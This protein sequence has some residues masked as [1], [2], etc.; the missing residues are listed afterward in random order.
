MVVY[1]QFCVCVQDVL[2]RVTVGE[3]LPN[4]FL[5]KLFSIYVC[6]HDMEVEG[7]CGNIGFLICGYDRDNFNTV[8]LAISCI[9]IVT[10]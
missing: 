9:G 1:R 6:T 10:M 2:E 8:S 7:L 3:F 5:I 4:D